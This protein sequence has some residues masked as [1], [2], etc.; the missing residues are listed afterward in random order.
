MRGE[1]RDDDGC[2]IA[3]L[4]EAGYADARE[5]RAHSASGATPENRAEIGSEHPEN[6]STDDMR[7]P[8]EKGD[9]GEQI[10]KN[11]HGRSISSQQDV[12]LTSGG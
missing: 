4:Y 11:Q 5:K 6:A 9:A 8:H 1:R 10:E 12:T 2:G 7:A 3:A